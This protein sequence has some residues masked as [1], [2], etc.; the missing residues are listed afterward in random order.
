MAKL[1][2]GIHGL[3]NKPKKGILTDYWQSAIAEG[4]EKNCGIRHS[5]FEFHLVYWAD[6]MYKHQ[7]HGDHAFTFDKLYNGE[8]YVAA[9]PNAL[10]RY[11]DSWKDSVRAFAFDLVGSSV[12]KMKEHFGID[13]VA[14]RVL[15]RVLKDLVFYYDPKRKIRNRKDPVAADVHLSDDYE[16]NDK[17]IK[18]KDD[19]VLNDYHKPGKQEQRNHHKSYG[20]LRT[21]EVSEHIRAFLELG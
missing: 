21:P 14:D 4:L 12:D 1:I 18:V 9:D 10:K 11:E 3:A 6:L 17:G 13:A 8:P 19:L 20:Y 7:L 2:I 15:G 5:A 16:A